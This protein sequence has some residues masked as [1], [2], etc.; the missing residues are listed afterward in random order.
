[1]Y[2]EPRAMPAITTTC[3][4]RTSTA[5]RSGFQGV[6]FSIEWARA[7]QKGILL[8]ADWSTTAACSKHATARSDAICHLFALHSPA[9]VCSARRWENAESADLFGRTVKKRPS[10]RGS[11][12]LS[13]T[14][15]TDIIHLLRW[16]GPVGGRPARYRHQLGNTERGSYAGSSMLPLQ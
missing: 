4:N 8:H 9:L 6:R 5:R 16:M 3:M 1:M 15:T 11:G 13:A 7:S 14:F 12:C 10:P 2:K